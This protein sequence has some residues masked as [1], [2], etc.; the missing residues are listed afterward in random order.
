M[1][2][3]GDPIRVE[4]GV[5]TFRRES[6]AAAVRSV[7][8][9][10]LPATVRLTILIADN[11]E[12]PSAQEMVNALAAELPVPIRYIHAPSRNIALARNAILNDATADILA[13]LDDDEIASPDWLANLLAALA[14]E[15]AD[16]A[17]GP[18]QALYPPTAPAWMVEGDFHS[19][20][21]DIGAA[22]LGQG[23]SC[24][25]AL[26]WAGAPWAQ[27]RFDLDLGR[28]GGEDTAFFQRLR[29]RGA[30]MIYAEDALVTEEA[31]PSRLSFAWLFTRRKRY[32]HTHARLLLAKGQCRICATLDSLA[33]AGLCY[34]VACA[35]GW[36]AVRRNR[37][38]LRGA[39]HHGAVEAL[40]GA[41]AMELY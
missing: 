22:R 3:M 28:S 30:K 41:K 14:R 16:V 39:L 5:C 27:E 21:L 19:N 31:A 4:V 23:Y 12:T 10:K 32:G 33:K 36:S 35:F 11:D 17:F 15:H 26:R 38:L 29:D 37:W 6:L 13:F 20:K 40:L 7:A 2:A 1:S 34:G 9:Q 25:V 8:A 24:N 18:A